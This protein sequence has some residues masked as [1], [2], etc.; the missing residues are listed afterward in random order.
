MS[1][2]LR[3]AGREHI[4]LERRTTL[5]GGWQDRWDEFCLVSPNWTTSLPGHDY[6]GPD[7]DGF[8]PRD[9]VVARIAGYAD[10]IGAPVMPGVEVRRLSRP[11][12]HDRGFR[13]ETSRGTLHADEVVVAT[14]G[15]H[16]P[17]IPPVAAAISSS[18][19][20]LHSHDYRNE[21]ALPPGG[22]L[23]VGTGQS[24]VQLA[25]ELYAAGRPVTLSVGKAG[26][27]PRRYRGQ[28]LFVWLNALLRRGPSVGVSMLTLADLP[29]PM[30]R[31]AGNPHLS[32]HDGGHETNLRRFAADGM[33][34]VGRLEAADGTRLRCGDDLLAT[35]TAVDQFFDTVFRPRFDRLIEGAGIA[36]PADDR[37]PF[38]FDPPVVRELDLAAEGI[39]TVVWTTGYRLDFGW[40]DLPILDELGVPIQDHGVSP[41]DGLSFIGLPWQ[42]HLASATLFG[43]GPDAEHLAGRW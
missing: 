26:R 13:L 2:F 21:A 40:I 4:L 37:Q 34:L 24:G 15:F 29:S 25:E 41:I 7:P 11:E 6:D 12:E 28:D 36:A 14:G 23:I 38:T 16:V 8:M 27:A 9:E 19:T 42:A 22:V 3:Q 20:Q 10:A 33:R 1:W 35:L 39:S 43:V 5:G 18:I 31:F 17:R 30:A 32:G